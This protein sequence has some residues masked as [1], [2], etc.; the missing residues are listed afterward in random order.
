MVAAWRATV[1][2][3]LAAMLFS[4]S[5]SVACAPT[6]MSGR[7]RLA[8]RV[9]GQDRPISLPPLMWPSTRC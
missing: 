6:A 2:P 3:K 1:V 5:A 8:V 4:E 9:E 7:S